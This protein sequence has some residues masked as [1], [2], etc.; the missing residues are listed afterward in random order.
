MSAA[1]RMA[2]RSIGVHVVVGEVAALDDA[3]VERNVQ[4]QFDDVVGGQAIGLVFDLARLVVEEERSIAVENLEAVPLRRIVTGGESEAVG[5]TADGRGVSDQRSGGVLVEE[6]GGNVVAGENLGGC[7]CRPAGEE[8][9]IVA[10]DDALFLVSL[11]GDLV[12]QSLAQTA[13]VLHG[14]AFADDG[15]P[16]A[17]AEGDE[18]LLLLAAG[19]EEALLH[20]ELG[21]REICGGVDALD[22]VLIVEAVVVHA[23]AGTN[24]L[25]DAVSE[26]IIT[27]TWRGR[28][29]RKGGEDHWGGDAERLRGCVTSAKRLRLRH[30]ME[31]GTQVRIGCHF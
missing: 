1:L 16:A 12:G 17:G 28:E 19:T 11:A 25:M 15:T 31:A 20:N 10:D 18:V 4:F 30:V 26:A 9:A 22:F 29:P 13:H 6:H 7:F 14:E 8:A 23:E 5:R 27:V 2:S 21:S 24:E 3:C